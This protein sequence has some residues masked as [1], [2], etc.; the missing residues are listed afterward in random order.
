MAKKQF[1]C[2]VTKFF[3][4]GHITVQIE[5]VDN[6]LGGELPPSK[7]SEYAHFDVYRDYFATKKQAQQAYDGYVRER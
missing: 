1:W 3:D 7:M 6:V 5:T 2:V 4:D